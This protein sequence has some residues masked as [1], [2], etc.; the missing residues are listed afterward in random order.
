MELDYTIVNPDEVSY[1]L[2]E[3]QKNTIANNSVVA[4]LEYGLQN[5]NKIRVPSQT[6]TIT[7]GSQVVFSFDKAYLANNSYLNRCKMIGT[8]KV[9]LTLNNLT[10]DAA[11]N[12]LSA[13]NYNVT[14]GRRNNDDNN[15]GW[16]PSNSALTP[17][18]LN[19]IL[20]RREID[21]SGKA[22]QAQSFLLPQEV[23]EL[24]CMFNQDTLE[25][26]GIYPEKVKGYQGFVSDVYSAG[27][28]LPNFYDG[29]Q[30]ALVWYGDSTDYAVKQSIYKRNQNG[31]Y[32]WQLSNSY[33]T[34]AGV[35]VGGLTFE[36][37]GNGSGLV[38][39]S[40]NGTMTNL[41]RADDGQTPA[42][43]QGFAE[44][45]PQINLTA[46]GITAIG[47][48]GYQEIEFVVEEDLISDLFTN[49]YVDKPRYYAMNS[50]ELNF[51][52]DQSLLSNTFYKTCISTVNVS[53][54]VQLTNLKLEFSTFNLGTVQIPFKNF[55]VP[56]FM[57]IENKQ[58]VV[59]TSFEGGTIENGSMTMP[60]ISYSTV[61][62]YIKIDL[63]ETANSNDWQL[64]TKNIGISAI[65]LQI[66]QDIGNALQQLNIQDLYKR[67]LKNLGMWHQSWDR[68]YYSSNNQKTFPPATAA[69]DLPGNYRTLQPYSF[70]SVNNS[71]G[72]ILPFLLLKVGTD[73]RL[74][75]GL[76][77]GMRERINLSFTIRAD[78]VYCSQTAA[79]FKVTA[80]RCAKYVL[81]PVTGLLDTVEVSTSREQWLTHIAALNTKLSDAEASGELRKFTETYDIPESMVLGGSWFSG[82]ARAVGPVVNSVRAVAR[83]A[84]PILRG[85]SDVADD[86]S[87]FDNL[88]DI[89]MGRK[90]APKRSGRSVRYV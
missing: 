52:F 58:Q 85:I 30:S 4:Q 69:A 87:K 74:Q 78:N 50:A 11:A 44:F 2:S 88:G 76:A 12:P 84:A 23:D 68:V 22:I 65:S 14:T 24:A 66:D 38:V 33:Y 79:E 57:S 55:E 43:L 61:P 40:T 16:N 48:G 35:S 83:K 80:Y 29:A 47:N 13:A 36:K 77:P 7:A 46:A 20:A 75:P 71:T 34:S 54:S 25:T 82:L 27:P 31:N 89:G 64:L 18:I 59:L 60:T 10:L 73:I 53:P 41:A 86:V 62:H 28:G 32:Y 17:F 19:K 15:H 56:F 39:T 70:P 45:N 72:P 42:A 63:Y 51:R 90:A 3:I 21:F 1:R 5:Q 81:S 67:T 26:L 37:A 9:K 8:V 49:I 6:D